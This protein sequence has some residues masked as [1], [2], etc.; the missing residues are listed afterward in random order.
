[1]DHRF[2]FG[3]VAAGALIGALLF[4]TNWTVVVAA[5]PSAPD[6]YPQGCVDCHKADGPGLLGTLLAE[7]KHRNVDKQTAKVPGDCLEC[8]GADGDYIPLSEAVHLVHFEDPAK[9][10]FVVEHGGNCL[11]CH[12]LDTKTGIVTVKSGPKN[13]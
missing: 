10:P 8:H 9:N 13:W 1:M 12:A 3:H 6:S 2:R 5:D 7:I 4:S 11:H